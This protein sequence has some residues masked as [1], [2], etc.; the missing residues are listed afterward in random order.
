MQ[1][2]T[3]ARL[4]LHPDVHTAQFTVLLGLLGDELLRT[5]GWVTSQ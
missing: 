3:N 2:F 4:E 1:Y 5:R